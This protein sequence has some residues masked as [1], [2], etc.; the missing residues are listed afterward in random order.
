VSTEIIEETDRVLNYPRIRERL[1]PGEADALV[2]RLK[3]IAE[4]TE[5]MLDLKVLT[6]DESDNAYLSCAVEGKADYLVTGNVAHFIEAGERYR[7]VRI[8][9]PREFLQVPGLMGEN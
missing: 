6:R 5:G 3:G 1:E 7:G 9:T 8:L 4:C 2:D